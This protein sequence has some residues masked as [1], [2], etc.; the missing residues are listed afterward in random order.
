MPENVIVANK[1]EASSFESIRSIRGDK[2]IA[3]SYP[4]YLVDES[5]ISGGHAQWLFFP[6]SEHEI[7]SII[8]KMKEEKQAIT[9][10]AARTG[11]VGS[12]VPLLGGAVVSLERMNDFIGLGYEEEENRW[13]VRVQPN[14]TLN[15]INEIVK[16]KKIEENQ[17]ILPE[18]N[19]IE[20]FNE[21][22]TMFYPIDPTEMTASIGGC[23]A[24]NASGA[25]T[26]KY[27]ATR[28]WVRRLRVIIST[29]EV[30]EIPRGKYKAKDGIFIIKTAEQEI[31]FKVP[32]YQL[33]KAKNAAGLY[34]TPDMDLIDLFI[35]SE[36]IFGFIT[37]ADVWLKEY[38]PHISNVV[39]FTNEADAIKF[40]NLLRNNPKFKPEFMEYFDNNAL[41]LLRDTQKV[42]PKFVNM[43]YIPE[44]ANTAISFDL[45]YNEDVLE[46]TF[47]EIALMLEECNASLKDTW[48]AYEERELD[49]FKHFRHAVPEIVNNIIADRKKKFPSIHK[50]GTDMSVEDEYIGEMMEFYHKILNEVGLQYVIWGHIGD[51]H[52]HVNILPKNME[53]LELGKQLYKKFAQKAVSFGGSV[54]AEHGIGKIKHEYLEIMFGN[55]AINEMRQ[56]KS[57]LDP[58]FLFNPGNI[59]SKEVA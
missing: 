42:D 16:L 49:R 50:L 44:E 45:G 20:K 18:K 29:G 23:I 59:F 27:G 13:F 37:E 25:R 8:S 52:V 55:E 43:P 9:I 4:G 36:G 11:I 5:K 21:E 2:K 33:P 40:V 34:T 28:E 38:I 17:C 56:V 26:F 15:E 39:F 22:P 19:W 48:S 3:E 41:S 10:S 54:S 51:N 24:A 35:G 30:L 12:A 57:T 58:N 46:E 1:V 31:Q 14:I 7:V 6:T 32:T 53:D 47:K